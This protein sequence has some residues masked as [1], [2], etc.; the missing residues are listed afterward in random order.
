MKTR[1]LLLLAVA[2]TFGMLSSSPARA[3]EVSIAAASDLTRCLEELNAAFTK[4]HPDA[5]L[6]VSNGSSGNFFAQIKNG[7]PFDVF[8]SADMSYPKQLA[9]AGLADKNSITLYAV[10]RIVL[11][12]T[13]KNIDIT[14]G[15]DLLK[16]ADLIKKIAIANP[17]HAPYGRAAK[18]ALEHFGLWE[19]VQ[20]RLV[21][22]ENISQ[23][24]QF[25]QTGNA[26]VGFVALSLVLD[27]K[28]EKQPPYFLIPTDSYPPLEQGAVLTNA[29]AAKPLAKA[30]L[31]FLRGDVARKIFDRYGFRLDGNAK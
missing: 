29:G 27:P 18:A 14:R 17:D 1:L 30:Y 13:N 10:G 11:W 20:P 25:V 2:L 19:S 12:S 5:T 8:L 23:T 16:D 6:K 22:G 15:L 21:L 4:E 24:A 28:Q 26:D 3:E 7:A 31:E 9:D